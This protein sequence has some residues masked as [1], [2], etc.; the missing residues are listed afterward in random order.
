VI[1]INK[2]AVVSSKQTLE[3]AFNDEPLKPPTFPDAN[4]VGQY[5]VYEN[6]DVKDVVLDTHQ[7]QANRIEPLFNH[8]GLIPDATVKVGEEQ[9]FLT[10]AGHRLA[11]AVVRFSNKASVVEEALQAFAKGD[12]TKVA[13]I[14]PT[15]LLFGLWDSR[16]T[17]TK[18]VRLFNSEIRAHNVIEV[19]GAGQ[20][21][22]SVPRLEDQATKD[23]SAEGLLDCPYSAKGG[24]L[25]KGEIVRN[26][27]FNIRAVRA[28]RGANAEETTKL[29][30]YV[31]ALG[32]FALTAPF[33]GD[34]REGCNLVATK[35]VI[36][37]FNEDGTREEITLKHEDVLGFATKAAQE[38]GLGETLEFIYEQNVANKYASGKAEAKEAR[39]IKK[40]S[41]KVKELATV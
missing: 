30:Q 20:F 36:S 25:V 10:E 18:I 2:V 40:K 13:K 23:L 39:E 28:L 1:D 19:P 4:G 15:S 16:K 7:S 11:D 27:R 29:Q 31:L 26:A 17:G 24:V 9:I 35:T 41:G 21:V 5:L 37:V 34:L 32:L 33:A 3:A 38:F 8:S 14:A 6:G 12:A 22:S